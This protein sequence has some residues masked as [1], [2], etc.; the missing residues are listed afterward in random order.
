MHTYQ[1]QLSEL[2]KDELK[3]ENSSPSPK[4]LELMFSR[5]GIAVNLIALFCSI[6]LTCLLFRVMFP[7]ADLADYIILW[8]FFGSIVIIYLHACLLVFFEYLSNRYYKIY[9][10]AYDKYLAT[11]GI[12]SDKRRFIEKEITKE[13]EKDF[14]NRLNLLVDQVE[15]RQIS[16]DKALGEE[17]TL[18]S[19]NDRWSKSGYRSHSGEYFERRFDRIRYALNNRD[20]SITQ[21]STSKTV[22]LDSNI[23]ANPPA[24]PIGKDSF[25]ISNADDSIVVDKKI[26]ELFATKKQALTRSNIHI[27]RSPIKIDYLKLQEKMQTVG[28]LGE[29]FVLG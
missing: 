11:K 15:K 24:I 18:K 4:S 2:E 1:D 14:V 20:Q 27:D 13:K 26:S 3:N 21:T 29:L 16:L 17:R 7:K 28:L 23:K 9:K 8:L 19:E 12:L 22:D 6:G 25:Q 10:E 5:I